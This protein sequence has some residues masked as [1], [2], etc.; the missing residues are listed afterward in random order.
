MQWALGDYVGKVQSARTII[1]LPDRRI[2]LP[3]NDIGFVHSTYVCTLI[4]RFVFVIFTESIGAVPYTFCYKHHNT[5]HHYLS[6]YLRLIIGA[7]RPTLPI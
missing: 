7:R 2:A 6:A 4:R 5:R 3:F 1:S